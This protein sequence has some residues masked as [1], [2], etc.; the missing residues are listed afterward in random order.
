MCAGCGL[1]QQS[2]CW[3]LH[4]VMDLGHIDTSIMLR[5]RRTQLCVAQPRQVE[6]YCNMNMLRSLGL[7]VQRAAGACL[8]A[9]CSTLYVLL[10]TV[11]N[12]S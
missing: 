9:C 4:T 8:K 12:S 7:G 11:C 3:F 1:V 10:H 5:E 6:S 2:D